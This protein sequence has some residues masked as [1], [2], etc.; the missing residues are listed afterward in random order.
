[1]RVHRNLHAA[2]RGDSQWVETRGGIVHRYHAT[3]ALGGVSCIVQPGGAARCARE[4]VRDVVAY[5]SGVQA[6]HVPSGDWLRVS[7]DPR[8]DTRF[9]TALG[10]FDYA[11]YAQLLADGAAYVLTPFED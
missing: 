6:A 2:R 4:G 10:P 3:L 11:D 8:T 7:F 1:M 5:F 9:R